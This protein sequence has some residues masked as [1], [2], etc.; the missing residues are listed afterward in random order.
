[1]ANFKQ[2][3]RMGLKG[4]KLAVTKGPKT[5]WRLT[6]EK[7]QRMQ[8]CRQ[9]AALHMISDEERARQKSAQFANPVKISIL[10]PLYN[11]PEPFLRA[12]IASLKAQTYPNWELC[13]AD[14]SDDAH[15]YVGRICREEAE[16]DPRIVYS[17]LEENGGIS[18][19]T[20]ACIRLASGAY[21]GLL[22]HDDILH[23]SAL[24]E[25]M[26][27]I[28]EKGAD[29]IYTDEVK[30]DGDVEKASDFNFKPGFGKDEL[31]SHN[32]ICHFTCYSRALL[33]STGAWYRPAFDGSQDH[34]IVLRLTERAR[35]IVH[36]PKVLY[37][38]RVHEQSVSMDLSTKQYA[39]DAA[40]HAV[41]EQL[42]RAGEKGQVRSNLPYQTIYRIR[43]EVDKELVSVLLYD[44]V[45]PEQAQRCVDRLI[46]S[47]AWRPLELVCYEQAVPRRCPEG[48]ALKPVPKQ[49]RLADS[50]DEMARAAGGK[51]LCLFA[52]ALQ[53]EDE[54]WLE[55]MA[56]LCQRPDV[57]AVGA[58]CYDESDNVLCAGLA[59]DGD[60]PDLI[61]ALCRG[62][63]RDQQGFEAMLRYVRNVTAL[64]GA[65]FLVKKQTWQ[66]LGGFHAAA[67]GYE[68]VEFCLAGV[69][70]GLWNVWTPFAECKLAEAPAAGPCRDAGA[71]LQ[72]WS[73]QAGEPDPYYHP[74]LKKLGLL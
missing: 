70:Q 42:Q 32:Y 47:T 27:A 34:D 74:N 49:E 23:E 62:I 60:K 44:A 66:A 50:L 20:N 4:V 57:C 68:T 24:Y 53:P 72:R 12:L 36:I 73:K 46:Q 29:F 43:Y 11:T 3:L 28:E 15:A 17:H 16:K 14:G 45:S 61:A 63:H 8:A 40:I 18:D 7:T 31:R 9:M 55:E 58:K 22:D 6:R 19:N 52:S 64:D 13:A 5:A 39:V 51:Y 26:R 30:F 41:A 38:W 37:Y 33:E 71:F 69:K 65:C 35:C 1:M 10:T 21:F 67:E 25:V 48:V 56:M 59:L 2:A 54:H